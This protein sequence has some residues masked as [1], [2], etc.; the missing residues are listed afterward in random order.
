M[1]HSPPFCLLFGLALAVAAGGCVRYEDYT[2]F[3]PRHEIAQAEGQVVPTTPPLEEGGWLNVSVVPGRLNGSPR[4]YALR[5][6]VNLLENPDARPSGLTAVRVDHV[7]IAKQVGGTW[8][9]PTD[10]LSEPITIL[11]DRDGLGLSVPLDASIPEPPPADLEALEV[12]VHTVQVTPDG[13]APR[14]FKNRLFP[15]RLRYPVPIH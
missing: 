4:P 15:F 11:L 5:L 2:A 3:V 12:E 14:V 10:L 1:S 8:G 13:E 7:Y 6:L 9:E